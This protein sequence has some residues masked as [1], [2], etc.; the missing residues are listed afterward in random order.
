MKKL[1][2]VLL[3]FGLVGCT[4]IAEYQR[5]SSGRVGC[6]PS[7]IQITDV[8]RPIVGSTSWTVDC[9]GDKYYCVKTGT[10]Y[11]RDVSCTQAK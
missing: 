5:E 6:A 11:V 3:C 1:L 9:K 7:D 4:S 8:N 2:V 10:K